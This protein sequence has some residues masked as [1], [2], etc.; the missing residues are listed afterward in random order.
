M[1]LSQTRSV[2]AYLFSAYA[3]NFDGAKFSHFEAIAMRFAN[4]FCTLLIQNDPTV[5]MIRKDYNNM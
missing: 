3:Y 1:D 5:I 2:H 4:I